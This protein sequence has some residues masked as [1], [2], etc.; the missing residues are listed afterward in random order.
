MPRYMI[1]AR[2][3]QQGI[4]GLMAEGG[5]S[6]RAAVAKALENLGGRLEAYYF[7]FGAEDAVV[8]A[9]LPDNA[10]AAAIGAAVGASGAG[11]TTT[12]VLLTPEEIDAAARLTVDYRPPGG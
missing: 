4:K 8:I 10:T 5:T 9:E 3:S 7:A 12:T 2:F 6:R 11:G 1:Q